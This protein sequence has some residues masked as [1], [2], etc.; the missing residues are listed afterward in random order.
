M[1]QGKEIPN[2]VAAYQDKFNAS[3][4]ARYAEQATNMF[5]ALQTEDGKAHAATMTGPSRLGH[6]EAPAEDHSFWNACKL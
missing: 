6:R 4:A 2:G 1:P 5:A 3:T